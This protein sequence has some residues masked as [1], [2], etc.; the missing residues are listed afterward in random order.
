MIYSRTVGRVQ[1]WTLQVCDPVK[2]FLLA[3]DDIVPRH[4]SRTTQLIVSTATYHPGQDNA[5]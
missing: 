1:G 4:A 5:G 3:G 2:K